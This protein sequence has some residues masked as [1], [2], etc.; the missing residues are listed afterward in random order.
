MKVFTGKGS[1]E[2][3]PV[4]GIAFFK[5]SK[6]HT[7]PKHSKTKLAPPSLHD[8][9]LLAAMKRVIAL[10]GFFGM[11]SGIGGPFLVSFLAAFAFPGSRWD[12]GRDSG[13]GATSIMLIPAISIQFHPFPA[14]RLRFGLGHS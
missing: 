5:I 8:R 2:H 12:S 3:D 10:G 14:C 1:R 11:L 4:S 6:W 13:Q 7:I 9:P